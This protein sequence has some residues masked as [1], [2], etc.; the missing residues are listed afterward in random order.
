MN[1]MV[2]GDGS[3]ERRGGNEAVEEEEEEEEEE[4]YRSSVG[5]GCFFL[6]LLSL[7]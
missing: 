6:F 2:M 3:R 5:K 4:E 7:H 1:L